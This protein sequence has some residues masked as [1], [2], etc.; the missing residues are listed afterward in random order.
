ML[1]KENSN[2]ASIIAKLEENVKKDKEKIMQLRMESAKYLQQYNDKDEELRL[3]K[4]ETSPV[5]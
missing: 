5:R 1:T 2:Q 4:F 3:Y